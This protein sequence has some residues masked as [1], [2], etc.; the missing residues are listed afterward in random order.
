[1]RGGSQVSAVY[2][3]TLV[4]STEPPRD[5]LPIFNKSKLST[6]KGVIGILNSIMNPLISLKT[7][8]LVDREQ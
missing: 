1:M 3:I 2:V 4:I 6:G 5:R 7:V 8:T